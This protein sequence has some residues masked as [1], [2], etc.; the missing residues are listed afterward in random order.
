MEKEYQDNIEQI[1][2]KAEQEFNAYKTES[3]NKFDTLQGEYDSLFT[4]KNLVS[5]ELHAIKGKQGLLDQVD[6]NSEDK[7]GEL[8]EEFLAFYDLFVDKWKDAKKQMRQE[9]L[10]SKFKRLKKKIEQ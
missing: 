10:W 9:I 2:L 7:F 4:K 8:E 1:K 5:A 6:F 3:E